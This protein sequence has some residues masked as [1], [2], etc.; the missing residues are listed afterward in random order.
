MSQQIN[1]YRPIFRKQEKKFSARAMLQAGA[2]MLVG[3]IALYAVLWWQVEGLRS[4]LRRAER[5]HADVSARLQAVT[6][7]FGARNP[8]QALLERAAQIE[9]EIAAGRRVQQLLERQLFT[10]TRGYADYFL[11][12][13]RQHVPGVWLTGF[14]IHG[15][16]EEMTLQGNT[17]DPVQVPRFVQ[18][19]SAESVLA[20]KE[21]QVFFMQRDKKPYA[22][23]VFQTT[24]L[25]AKK[26]AE[27]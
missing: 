1:L 17:I 26:E 18:R 6:E 21:F 14:T 15:A 24:P 3:I 13:A 11:A 10:N 16:G 2:V 7:K 19:L 12:F 5:R 4:E 25:Q 23:F 20:G 27:R 9:Q 8:S 22:E